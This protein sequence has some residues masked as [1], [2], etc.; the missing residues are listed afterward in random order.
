MTI[1]PKTPKPTAAE[2]KRAYDLATERDGGT[3]LFRAPECAGAVQLDH[4][5]N[6]S[7]GGLTVLSNLQ[8]LCVVHHDWKTNHPEEAWAE[9]WGVP[10][11]ADPLIWPARRWFKG[12]F[13]IYTLGWVLY[14]DDGKF[15]EITD[16]EAA[17][18]MNGTVA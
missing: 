2:E 9:G 10:G 17:R 16:V 6:R 13:G 8:S 18:R 3:C 1:L 15:L 7:Q 12:D 14:R 4:R 11:W 5:R